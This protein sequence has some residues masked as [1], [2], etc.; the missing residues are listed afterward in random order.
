MLDQFFFLPDD[1]CANYVHTLVKATW[2]LLNS[3]NEHWLSFPPSQVLCIFC[4]MSSFNK[5]WSLPCSCSCPKNAHV[6]TF[7]TSLKV[8]TSMKRCRSSTMSS[9][10]P[11]AWPCL[12]LERRASKNLRPDSDTLL[13]GVMTLKT[14][15]FLLRHTWIHSKWKKLSVQGGSKSIIFCIYI[16]YIYLYIH[17][18]TCIFWGL[19]SNYQL[20]WFTGHRAIGNLVWPLTSLTLKLLKAMVREKF[21]CIVDKNLTL[22]RGMRLLV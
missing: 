8:W 13:G 1:F 21:S 12:S 15:S 4:G 6:L 16:I 18:H 19:A 17:I 9:T 5:M 11:M 7:G 20:F 3:P 10:L 14:S 2:Q 22:P